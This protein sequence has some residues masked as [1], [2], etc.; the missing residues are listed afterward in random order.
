MGDGDCLKRE[1]EIGDVV[2]HKIG[3]GLLEI[4]G[5]FSMGTYSVTSDSCDSEFLVKEDDIILVCAVKDRR[6][7]NNGQ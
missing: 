5:N 3:V 4:S 1:Y 7:L 2:R 6:D